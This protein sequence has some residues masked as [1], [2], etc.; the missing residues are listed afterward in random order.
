MLTSKLAELKARWHAL[1]DLAGRLSSEERRLSTPLDLE[2][3]LVHAALACRVQ[4]VSPLTIGTLLASVLSEIDCT[5]LAMENVRRN[6]H[7]G[8]DVPNPLDGWRMHDARLDAQR[9]V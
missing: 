6:E 7:P 3:E 4:L 9:S 5:E 1:C 2:D 8:E